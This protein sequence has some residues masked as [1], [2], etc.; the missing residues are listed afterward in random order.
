[1]K[2][3]NITFNYFHRLKA[4]PKRNNKYYHPKK[5]T[6]FNIQFIHSN[7]TRLITPIENRHIITNRLHHN[8]DIF[9]N[10]TYAYENKTP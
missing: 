2:L 1:M 5:K 7:E 10:R 9:P 6:H 3:K 4:T 8:S